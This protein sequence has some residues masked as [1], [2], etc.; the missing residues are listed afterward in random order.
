MKLSCMSSPVRVVS[1]TFFFAAYWSSFRQQRV[2]YY[3]GCG[4]DNAQ[5]A[6]YHRYV[7]RKHAQQ[8]NIIIAYVVIV[9]PTCGLAKL[10]SSLS[11]P[12]LG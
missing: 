4:E 10:H 8:S 2:Y 9:W 12:P 1:E 5:E 7:F 11:S 6:V 3:S